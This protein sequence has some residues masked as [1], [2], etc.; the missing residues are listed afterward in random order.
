[1]IGNVRLVGEQRRVP[2]HDP[3]RLPVRL[4]GLGLGDVPL[5]DHPVEHVPLPALAGGE[6]VQGGVPGR[7]RR[8]AR[9]HGHLRK[10]EL[11]AFLAEIAETC[12][13]DPVGPASKIDPVEVEVQDLVLGEGPFDAQGQHD[14]P[15][16][17]GY[18]L[19]AGE[20]VG[21]DH[22]L[23]DGGGPLDIGVCLDVCYEGAQDPAR[24]EADVIVER[25]VLGRHDGLLEGDGN[26]VPVH[27]DPA[28]RREIPYGCPVGCRDLAEPG[29]FISPELLDRGEPPEDE[30]IG[31][32]TREDDC[33]RTGEKHEFEP[34]HSLSLHISMHVKCKRKYPEHVP[35]GGTGR[36][37]K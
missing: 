30:Q 6:I 31:P 36:I 16:F 13:L 1:M 24:L 2:G 34:S 5:V 20:Q 35:T 23:R 29:G 32:H 27:H 11:P 28:L 25:R 8:Q 17:A 15:E 4:L 10:F 33:D 3:Q 12:R 21:P 9:K 26:V 18:G 19:F 37:M 22:L 7:C 14:L